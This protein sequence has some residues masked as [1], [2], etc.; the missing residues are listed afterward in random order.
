MTKRMKADCANDTPQKWECNW[1]RSEGGQW[2]SRNF[3]TQEEAAAAAEQ[4]ADWG[5]FNANWQASTG[6]ET[7]PAWTA[8]DGERRN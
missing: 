2:Q 8:R 7:C 3:N 4:W 6:N 5:A 1:Q